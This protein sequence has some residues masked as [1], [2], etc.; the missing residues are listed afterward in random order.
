MH[1]RLRQRDFFIRSIRALEPPRHILYTCIQKDDELSPLIARMKQAGRL[2]LD[3][4]GDSL[5][6]YFQKICLIQLTID[7]RNYIIDPLSGMDLSEFLDV[8]A[9]KPLV[10]HGAEYDLRMM[11]ASFGFIPRNEIFDT[12]L[13]GVI[14]GYDQLGLV[15]LV[16]RFL[17]VE[18]SKKGQKSDWSRRPLSDEQLE[19]AAEDTRYL[20]PLANCLA[21]ELHHLARTDWHKEICA[22]MVRLSMIDAPEDRE[23][24]WRIPGTSTLLPRQMAYVRQIWYWREDEARHADL[25]SFKI[26]DSRRIID[27]AVWATSHN[28]HSFTGMPSLP[29][30]CIGR[31]L[32]AL[33][34]ALIK[35]RNIPKPY[36]P[37]PRKQH[38][39]ENKTNRVSKPALASLREECAHIAVR[40]GIAPSVLAP[41]AA[42]AGLIRSKPRNIAEIMAAGPLM[43]W[44]AILVKPALDRVIEHL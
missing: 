36:L 8:L 9:S 26:L 25:P 24:E 38:R 12:M 23:N 2:A 1:L 40:L 41:R 43:R 7:G 13:A 29:R 17:N 21:R 35:A 27:I 22:N 3:T 34:K 32:N 42:L 16:K 18:L 4:E 19:Y 31:R 20:A 6:H 11:R 28:P 15:A 37:G 14:L 44:Q 5:H 33:R 10:L 39:Q 30:N